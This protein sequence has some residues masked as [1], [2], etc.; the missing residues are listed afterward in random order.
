MLEGWKKARG[1]QNERRGVSV[2]KLGGLEGKRGN[3]GK[4]ES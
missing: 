2:D 4:G 3:L 1:R